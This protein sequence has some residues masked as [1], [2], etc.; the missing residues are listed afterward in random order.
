M[1]LNPGKCCYV[2]FGSNSDKSGLILEDSAKIPSAEEHVVLGV[3]VNNWL[4]F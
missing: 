1:V 3:T 2:S 4:T